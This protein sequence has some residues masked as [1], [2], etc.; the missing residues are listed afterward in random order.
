MSSLLHLGFLCGE[1]GL[2]AVHRVLIV[3]ASLVE[4][5]GLKGTQVA[6]HGLRCHVAGGVFA[7]QGWNR[8]PL[9][10]WQEDS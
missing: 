8:C 2:G 4:E 5:H 3:G 10:S 7:E 6:V 9:L 1:R